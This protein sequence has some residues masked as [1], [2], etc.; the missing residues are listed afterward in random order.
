MMSIGSRIKAFLAYL[1]LALGG[2]LILLISRKDGF[3]AFHARQSIALTIVAILAPIIWAP[4]AYVV[5]FIPFAGPLLA[6]ASFALV[7]ALFI[8]LIVV[9]IIGMVRALRA[10]MSPLPFVGG[11]AT[12]WLGA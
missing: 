3:A 7:I 9:W 11:L 2:I 12:R 10:E 5:G 4:V 6:S 8:V 1:F